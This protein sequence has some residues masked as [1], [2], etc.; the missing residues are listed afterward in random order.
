M[1]ARLEVSRFPSLLFAT[2]F[3]LV[4]ALVLG[5]VLGYALKPAITVP[6]RT[7]VLVVHD[8]RDSNRNAD[9]CIWIDGHKA[10]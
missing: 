1:L 8:Q 7:D 6:G 9:A 5:G 10:C 4:A 3:A 2:L